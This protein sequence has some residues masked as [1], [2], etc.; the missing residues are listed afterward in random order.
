MR[1]APD[2]H[3][4]WVE[5]RVSQISPEFCER[6]A[7]SAEDV[8][9]AFR[10]WNA[11][12]VAHGAR[13]REAIASMMHGN[14]GLDARTVRSRLDPAELG[15]IPRLRMIQKHIRVLRTGW[16]LRPEFC[17]SGPRLNT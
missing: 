3:E 11:G 4:M 12:R 10:A 13:L 5:S 17:D 6:I 16:Q 8:P 2:N 7:R 9:D 15:R 14:D 1:T